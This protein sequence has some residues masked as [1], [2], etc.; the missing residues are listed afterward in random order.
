M[1]R[2][3][4]C[5][6]ATS[7]HGIGNNHHNH[8]HNHNNTS[9]G[10]EI[11]HDMDIVKICLSQCGTTQ[12]DRR[13]LFLDRKEDLFISPVI[14]SS[15]VVSLSSSSVVSSSNYRM[16]SRS[17][18]KHNNSNHHHNHTFIHKLSAQVKT[19]AWNDSS[20]IVIAI[21]GDDSSLIKTWYYPNAPFIDKDLLH[22]A[23]DI[24]THGSKYG[25][26]SPY[27]LY[28]VDTTWKLRHSENGSHIEATTSPYPVTVYQLAS[29][30]KWKQALRVCRLANDEKVWAMMAGLAMEYND[31]NVAEMAWSAI[32]QV[33]KLQYIQYIQNIKHSDVSGKSTCSRNSV[34]YVTN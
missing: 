25:G 22:L 28:F 29:S 31:L 20:N 2:L 17:N 23:C 21:T 8:N 27:I 30:G 1:I 12:Q 5:S 6:T 3:F 26:T 10:K 33:D 15:S 9:T 7:I 32:R 14:T 11:R 18:T 19:M 34:K 13:L 16:G 24:Q 4:D